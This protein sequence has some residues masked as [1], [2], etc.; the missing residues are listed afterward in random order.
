MFATYLHRI[1]E[2]EII[3]LACNLG[4]QRA[5]AVGLVEVCG[6]E[7]VDA[8]LVMDSDGE[9]RPV[10]IPRMLEEATRRPGHI[11]YAKRKR[12]PGLIVFP[13]WYAFYKAVFRLLT[14]ARID[15]GNFCLIPGEKVE[16][17]I[18]NSSSGTIL[19]PR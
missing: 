5:L 13:V 11:I 14:G 7:G 15:F 18:S 1:R 17:L 3:G 2:I 16:A 12:R 8:V 6:R 9:D 19:L 10:D 4:H